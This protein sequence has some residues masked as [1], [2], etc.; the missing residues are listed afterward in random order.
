MNIL[1]EILYAYVRHQSFYKQQE[2]KELVK[3]AL[4]FVSSL[5]SL[6][7]DTKV[8][9]IIVL[10]ILSTFWLLDILVLLE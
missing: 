3:W 7:F 10:V 1:K 5:E 4:S 6:N 2:R 9:A 8:I